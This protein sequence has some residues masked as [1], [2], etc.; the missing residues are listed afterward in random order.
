MIAELG[1]FLIA[2][3]LVASFAQMALSWWVPLPGVKPLPAPG[4]PA[5]LAALVSSAAAFA[6]LIAAFIQSDFSIAYV[7]GH[8]HVDKPLFYKVTAAWGGHE[9]S[10]LLWCGILALFGYGLA[11]IGPMDANLRTRAVSIQGLLQTLF[12][13]FLAF[14]SNPFDRL[15]PAPL[16]GL[17]LNPI[18]QDPALAFHPPA[19]LHRLC[20]PLGRFRD[21]RSR[22]DPEDPRPGAGACSP[23][24]GPLGAWTSLTAGISLGPGGPITSWAGAAGGSG[25]RSRIASFMP[26]LL[27]AALHPLI[28]RDRKA[29]RLPRL[30]DI[31]R[32]SGLC[33][34]HSGRVPGALRRYHLGACLRARS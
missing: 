15:D 24:L 25:I 14:A 23:A 26:W 20:G 27:G 16:Q 9:G 12:F 5:T 2:L 33:A 31:P 22:V 29:R 28:H 30:D 34:L 7:A 13:A 11:R 19:S 21:C 1:R 32:P 18:L 6:L 4:V 8:S 17:D 3:A 10:M